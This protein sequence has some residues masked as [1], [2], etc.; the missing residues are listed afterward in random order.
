MNGLD[1]RRSVPS[2]QKAVDQM[3]T[4]DRFGRGTA[5]ALEFG[6]EAAEGEQRSVIVEREPHHVLFLRL[7]VRLRRVLG[8]AVGR[9]QTAVLRDDC[10][11]QELCWCSLSW[12]VNQRR[13]WMSRPFFL[14]MPS[15]PQQFSAEAADRTR[16]SAR[17]TV[18]LPRHRRQ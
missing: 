12:S 18:V 15:R 3:R 14:C 17:S 8:K 4:W 7:R 10:R 2:S 16:S 5:V 6:P 1:D 9:D 11:A 13:F